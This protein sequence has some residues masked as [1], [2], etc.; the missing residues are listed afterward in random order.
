MPR[1]AGKPLAPTLTP[2]AHNTAVTPSS[3][4]PAPPTVRDRR[5]VQISAPLSWYPEIE[6]RP[7]TITV[8]RPFNGFGPAVSDV[9]RLAAEGEVRR[10]PGA[11]RGARTAA[12]EMRRTIRVLVAL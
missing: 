8:E 11:P 7:M 5:Q 6:C 3:S 1:T 9:R 12:Y 10:R 2:T 4:N